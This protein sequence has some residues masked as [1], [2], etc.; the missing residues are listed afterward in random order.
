MQQC[1]ERALGEGVLHQR[2]TQSLITAVLSPLSLQLVLEDLCR[3]QRVSPCFH[4]SLIISWRCQGSLNCM[5]SRQLLICWDLNNRLIFWVLCS[6]Q[7]RLGE[8]KN[9]KFFSTNC[10]IKSKKGFKYGNIVCILTSLFREFVSWTTVLVYFKTL[11]SRF[12][13][14][15]FINMYVSILWYSYLTLW[16][17]D[18]VPYGSG[19]LSPRWS[20]RGGTRWPGRTNAH[21]P[22][23]AV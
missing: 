17:W 8:K 6:P 20:P 5:T 9:V 1:R 4:R 18:I 21:Q 11:N 10:D 2:L 15:V 3:V 16:C 22:L 14:G 13:D 7:A 12:W 23:R 19:L